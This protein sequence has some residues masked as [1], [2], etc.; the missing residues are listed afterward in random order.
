LNAY[1]KQI[2]NGYPLA[3]VVTT[4]AIAAS[5]ANNGMEYFNTFGGSPVSCAIGLAVL[6]IIRDE[7]LQDHALQVGNHLITRLKELATRHAI[8]GDVRGRG[9]FVGVELVRDR[10]SL[11][12]AEKETKE[13]VEKMK[14]VGVLMGID[15]P[16]HN[17]LKIKPP[18]VLSKEDVD[19]F[20][21]RFDDVLASLARGSRANL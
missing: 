18:I 3:G 7:K 2:G 12:P 19:F 10:S 15:G 11:E 13:I 9:L 4:Q 20:V 21:D 16:Y 1:V 8:I 14:E 17:V 6:D 5:F